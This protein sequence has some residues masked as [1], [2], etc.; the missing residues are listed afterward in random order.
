MTYDIPHTIASGRPEPIEYMRHQVM[1]RVTAA[2]AREHNVAAGWYGNFVEDERT[3]DAHGVADPKAPVREG[4]MTYPHNPRF[5]SNY[6][7]LTNRLDLLLECYS[8]ISFEERVHAT[9]A[10]LL[11]ALRDVAAHGDEVLQLVASSQTP[12]DTIAVRYR[13]DAFDGT[14]EIPTRNPRTLDGAP[15]TVQVRHFSNFVGTVVVDRPAAYIVPAGVAAHLANHGLALSDPSGALDVE[16]ARVSGFATEDG[17][18]ILEASQVGM[19]EVD[20]KT[21]RRTPPPGARLVRADQPLG[22]IAV[23]LCEPE[24]DDG[25]IENGL[26][27]SPQAGDEYPIWRVR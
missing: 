16:V 25:A 11:E 10:T 23:Y 5:G 24:S 13:L 1:P 9:Y 2:L 8:Y 6:R 14:I 7:G 15:A 26:V 12:R 4:W 20:W 3:L 21:E 18:K 22:A 27:A 19:L 17:R